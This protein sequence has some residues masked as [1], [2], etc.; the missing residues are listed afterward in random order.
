MQAKVKPDCPHQSVAAAGTVFS[1]DE[2]RPVP[3][4]WTDR[5]PDFYG[6]MLVFR[7]APKPEPGELPA[8]DISADITAPDPVAGGP[9]ADT[10]PEIAPKPRRKAGP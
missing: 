10:P 8:T 7:D 2:W 6:D 9:L 5:L 3:D 4:H 1:K